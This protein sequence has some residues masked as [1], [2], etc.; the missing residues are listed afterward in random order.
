MGKTWSALRASESIV[1]L[2]ATASHRTRRALTAIGIAVLSALAMSSATAAPVVF[3]YTGAKVNWVVPTTGTYRVIAT[4]AQGASGAAGRSGG[5]GAQM[6]GEFHLVAGATYQI[7]VGGAGGT[8]FAGFN[9]GVTPVFNGGGGGGTFFV[10]SVNTP[11][12]IAGGGGGIRTSAGQNGTDATTG[13]Y[14][15]TAS[16]SN[17]TY[18]PIAKSTNLGDG[19]VVS[20]GT[21]GAGG[22]GFNSD[23]ATD[24][25][26]CNG[27]PGG[28][29]KSWANGIGGGGTG[30]GF[31]GG[32]SGIGCGGGGGGGGFSGGD[33]GFI[34]G[35]GSS[36]NAGSEQVAVAGVG[37]GNGSLSVE[38]LP[39]PPR[40]AITKSHT[41]TFTQGGVGS[42]TI[43][44]SNTGAGPTTGAAVVVTD[45]LPAGYTLASYS[46]TG[47]TC[48]GTTTV[49]CSTTA[50]VA[51]G[52]DFN[53]LQLNVNIPA[54]SATSV[55]NQASVYGGGDT[56]YTSLPTALNSNNHFVTVVQVAASLN[57]NAGTPQSATILSAFATPLSAIV[58]DAGNV[59]IAGASVT[60]T[61]PGVGASAVFS[62]ATNTISVLTNASGIATAPVSA[63]GTAGGP[64][65]VNATLGAFTAVF[66]LTNTVGAPNSITV[67]GGNNQSA[68]ILTAF[69]SSISVLV[70]DAGSNPISGLNVTFTA[71]G[72]GAS[73]VFS[74]AT[75]TITVATN[76]FGIASAPASANGTA[77]GPYA[78]SA[79]A[80]ALSTSFSLTNTVGAVASLSINGG[81]NQSATILTAFGSALSVTVRDAGSNPV[82]GASVTFTAPA[83]GASGVFSNA[84]NTIVVATNAS[85]V[86]SAPV[87]AN[88][89]AG[90]PYNVSAV[91]GVLSASF[92]LTNT[93]GAPASIAVNAGNNQSTT[94]STTFATAM[95]VVV[96]DA[97]SNPVPGVNVSWTAPGA[98]ASGTFPGNIVSGIAMTNASGIASAPSFTANGTAGSYSVPAVIGALSAPFSMSN[99]Q[100]ATTTTIAASSTSVFLGE[101]VTFTAHVSPSVAPGT[102]TFSDGVTPICSNIALVAGTASCTVSFATGGAHSVSAKYNGNANYTV[103]TSVP[104]AIV[105]VTDQRFKTVEA[106]GNFLSLRNDMLLSHEPEAGRQIDRLLQ[107]AQG[108][109]SSFT[110]GDPSPAGYGIPNRGNFAAGGNA[111][112]DNTSL[113][114]FAGAMGM[115]D[116][117]AYSGAFD[118]LERAIQ[119][120]VGFDGIGNDTVPDSFYPQMGSLRGSADGSGVDVSFATSLAEIMRSAGSADATKLNAYGGGRSA[121]RFDVWLQ[122][123]YATFG[124]DRNLTD[125]SGHFGVVYLGADY[126]VKPWLLIGGM[127][128][129]D[130]MK[131]TSSIASFETQGHGWM[132]GPY[133]TVRLSDGLFLQARAAWGASNNEVSPFLTYTDSFDSTR[134]LISGALTGNWTD[135]AW[136]FRPSAKF[137]YIEDTSDAYLDTF[138]VLIPSVTTSLGQ[139]EATPEVSY[140]HT[141]DSGTRLEPRVAGSLIWNFDSSESVT[142]FGGTL[143]GPQELRGK[144]EAG[145]GLRFKNGVVL[146]IAGS[147]D[148]IGSDDYEATSVSAG[149][150]I[151]MN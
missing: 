42:Y 62:N 18:S 59:P 4:G 146:D 136:Q 85:G 37:T 97:G 48:S 43:Q 148:G 102:V 46:G 109:G 5:R 40:L 44:V 106:I 60:F 61:A 101:S 7:A 104:A 115:R 45:T 30:G 114:S 8:S 24:V 94:I 112:L 150:R 2:I 69:G 125:S 11:L 118:S 55:G 134:W 110:G 49:S 72:S 66:S 9:D 116:S 20:A 25:A 87:S 141:F 100:A 27:V 95:S 88:A 68:T 83:S 117:G 123:Q 135:G 108:G 31:G 142:A 145:V 64:Y 80:G 6:T 93:V 99:T 120:S 144:V 22:A 131:Q 52:A 38:L 65:A 57:V 75:N 127:V 107:F 133:A 113:G 19:G 41:G 58:R 111:N 84:T 128:Q 1:R 79:Q 14:A 51:N 3:N 56:L 105:T 149:V 124:D 17:S 143:A 82:S 140:V 70:Q 73:G 50:I 36:Y 67:N 129:Y 98:G 71:P 63:N 29:G 151:P 130:Q 91:S 28:G 119:R 96:R 121:S 74:N 21:Y 89:T 81:N 138:G 33:G 92:S 47:W 13:L 39:E 32:G 76:I 53:L 139:F 132:A 34:A 77:G 16:G 23:G 122:G 35:G 137:S 90:G 103:S 10:N 15:M 12:L 26:S 126:V 147:Y 78:V 54:N 86:A